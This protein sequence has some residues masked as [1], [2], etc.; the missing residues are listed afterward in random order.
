MPENKTIKPI[1]KLRSRGYLPHFDAEG[2]TQ[3]VTFR[4]ADSLPSTIFESLKFKLKTKQINEIEYHWE[5]E[6]AL[7]VG[8][9]PIFLKDLRIAAMVAEAILKFAGQRFELHAWVIMLNRVHL[10]FTPIQP[11][12]VS[13]IVH[14]IKSYTANEA[15]KIL[16]SKGRFWSPDYFDRF[17]RGKEHFGRAKKYIDNNPVKAGLCKIPEEWPWGSAGFRG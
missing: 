13:E 4:L 10:L 1:E 6:K 12:S 3:F 2:F 16:N 9:G 8:R 11:H 14:S 17:I 15:N 5:V 7:D